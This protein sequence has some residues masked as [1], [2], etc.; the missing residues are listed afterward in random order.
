MGSW[1]SS[2]GRQRVRMV[3]G[4]GWVDLEGAGLSKACLGKVAA[5]DLVV[6]ATGGVVSLPDISGYLDSSPPISP[7]RPCT[8][9]PWP[10]VP[11]GSRCP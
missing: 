5:F 8:V 2:V 7:P 3:E 6:N 4:N 10:Q 9:R 11:M 1:E